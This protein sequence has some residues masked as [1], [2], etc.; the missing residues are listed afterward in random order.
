MIPSNVRVY[1][2]GAVA[3][4]MC[5][6]I[7][8]HSEKAMVARGRFSICLSGGTTPRATY[9]LLATNE[10]TSMMDWSQTTIFFGDERCVPPNHRDSNYR[11][12]KESLLGY[13]PVP[14]TNVHRIQGELPPQ[15]AAEQYEQ[16]LRAHFQKRL[17]LQ[18]P[19]F[20]LLLL[21]I[22][23]DG[24]TA[25]LFPGTVALQEQQKWVT[26]YHVPK[27][28]AWRVTLTYPALNSAANVLIWATGIEKAD[29]VQKVFQGPKQPDVLPI[30][31]IQPTEGTV[32]W[33]LDE[34]AASK[35]K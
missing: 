21:G 6:R 31:G 30:Q 13:V 22:G 14:V 18:K 11:M 35:I 8:S 4:M 29:A 33:I 26:A 1:P 16:V 5:E 3:R 2:T 25:S 23:T 20:D 17:G 32:N 24:H 12:A 19:R 28:D 34:A 7:A 10:F 9:E 27:L 15:D